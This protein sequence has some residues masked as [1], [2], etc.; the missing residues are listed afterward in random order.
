MGLRL[1]VWGLLIALLSYYG[2]KAGA[3]TLPVDQDGLLRQFGIVHDE[4][5]MAKLNR[6]LITLEKKQRQYKRGQ[7]FI[8]YLYYFT[9]RKLL[10]KYSQYPSLPE[11]LTRGN[12]DCLTATTIYSL[13]LTELAVPHT[14]VETNY[15]IYLLVYPDTENEILLE[16]T[17][18]RYGFISEKR[19]I[20]QQKATYRLANSE[21][22]E[23]Q[24]DLQL[25]IERRLNGRELTGLLYYNQSIKALNNGDLQQAERLATEAG[26]YYPDVRVDKL[27]SYIKSG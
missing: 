3:I 11:T 20:E 18:P 6:V 14:V 24:I 15:H 23:G 27:L 13:L 1:P 19:L 7:D 26:K 12:Y 2:S 5:A 8:E 22:R 16:P 25:N 10:K 21:L 9:H 4:V 17:D